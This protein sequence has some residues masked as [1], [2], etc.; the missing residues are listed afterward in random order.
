M[1]Q[2]EPTRSRPA[3]L[4]T[5][6]LFVVTYGLAATAPAQVDD[7]IDR[8]AVYSGDNYQLLGDGLLLYV[9]RRAGLQVIDVADPTNPEI[10]GRIPISG[11]PVE[12]HVVDNIAYVLLND[13]LSYPDLGVVRAIDLRDPTDPEVVDALYVRGHIATSRLVGGTDSAVLYVASKEITNVV[14]NGRRQW[15]HRTVISSFDLSGGLAMA[16]EISLDGSV[17]A[18]QAAPEALMVARNAWNSG[19]AQSRVSFIDISSPEGIM[20]LG[21]EVTTQGWINNQF[22]MDYRNGVL[23][24]F[25]GSRWGEDAANWVQTF[26]ARELDRLAPIS[27]CRFGSNEGLFGTALLHDRA[28]ASTA[29]KT[30]NTFHA[31]GL[32]PDGSCQQTS[33]FVVSGWNAYFQPVADDKRLIGIGV[34]ETVHRT[35]AVSLY[36]ITDLTN[37]SPLVARAEVEADY[38]WSEA[39]WDYR[40]F[41]VLENAV[42]GAL[43]TGMVLLPFTGWNNHSSEYVSAVQIFTFSD[44][45]LTR[46]GVMEHGTPVR[47]S[48]QADEE[49]VANLSE[50][51]LSLFDIAN[52]EKPIELG[53]LDLCSTFDS[54]TRTCLS[55][56]Q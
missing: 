48:F 24:V 18:V 44:A 19:D 14:V 42:G 2:R 29:G 30:D 46:M 11:T 6:I 25:S 21:D 22:N 10:V 51:A 4:L 33:E 16:S 31:F 13:W 17:A 32:F 49:T 20:T 55:D 27:E 43:E 52:P 28:F 53:R 38:S 35:M 9:N 40:A 37:P 1:C 47:R 41:S 7:P 34:D 3:F 56:N 36:D 12:M 54:L 50:S 26:D 45:T 23:R 39:T 5:A 15:R 8:T